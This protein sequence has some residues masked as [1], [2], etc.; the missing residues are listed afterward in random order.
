MSK[1]EFALIDN[2]FVCINGIGKFFTEN[3]LPISISTNHLKKQGIFFS[4]SRL[5]DELQNEGFKLKTVKRKV[6]EELGNELSA[7]QKNV[8]DIFCSSSYE[9]QR[10]IIFNDLFKSEDI[11]REFF[12][13]EVLMYQGD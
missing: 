11:A 4:V 3:G 12:R 7:E 8:I 5:C 2:K 1:L 6:M 10:D 13:L 9:N